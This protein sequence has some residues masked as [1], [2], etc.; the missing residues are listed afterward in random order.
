MD[1]ID[2]GK[3]DLKDYTVGITRVAK[4]VKG[5]KRFGFNAIMVV[6]DQAGRVGVGLGKAN[7]VPEAIKKGIESAK[8]NIIAIPMKGNTIT[9]EIQA[10]YGA[11][12]IILKPA[13]PGT[14]VIAGGAVRAIME[15]GGVKDILTKAIGSTNPHNLVKAT[16][17]AISN[18]K[19]RESVLNLRGK[20]LPVTK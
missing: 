6:G 4:V 9:H 20:E 10:H 14:G 17:L 15:L 1:N 2:I 18:L 3:T 7:Q 13:S 12:K 5:G 8:K 11:T 16:M 19:S